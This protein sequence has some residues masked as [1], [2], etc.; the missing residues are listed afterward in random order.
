MK[1]SCWDCKIVSVLRLVITKL[2]FRSLDASSIR[3]NFEAEKTKASERKRIR[4]N[5]FRRILERV[6]NSHTT[7]PGEPCGAKDIFFGRPTIIMPPPPLPV[8]RP[9]LSRLHPATAR[10][11]SLQS[12]N[13]CYFDELSFDERPT[14]RSCNTIRIVKFLA[15][16]RSNFSFFSNRYTRSFGF[17]L[18]FSWTS[19]RVTHSSDEQ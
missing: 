3:A 6:I 8:S 13:Y 18:F 15:L 12:N 9:A 2:R 7:R 19:F 17:G 5:G 4:L 10:S 14:A 11:V 1:L 16:C